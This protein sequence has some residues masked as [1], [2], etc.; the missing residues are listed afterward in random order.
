MIAS[1]CGYISVPGGTKF[2]VSL[3]DEIAS[4]VVFTYVF[5]LFQLYGNIVRQ[6]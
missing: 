3:D 1:W 2:L 4:K 6:S 5:L